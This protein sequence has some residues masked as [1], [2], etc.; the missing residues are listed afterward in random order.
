[1]SALFERLSAWLRRAIGR[2]TFEAD[3]AAELEFHIEAHADT[4]ERRGLPRAEALRQARLKFGATEKYR[5]EGREVSRYRHLDDLHADLR[6]AFRGLKRDPSFAV[7]AIAVVASVLA[8]N[9]VLLAFL[10]PYF[11]RPLPIDG[12]S[13]HVELSVRDG[14]GRSQEAWPLAAANRLI[15]ED[16]PV[17]ER[18]YLFSIR[19]VIVGGREPKRSYVEV[20]S[21]S[22]FKLVKPRL[23]IG[24]ALSADTRTIDRAILLSHTGWKRLTDADPRVL[25][26]QLLVDGDSLSVAGVLA[27]GTGGL[28]PVT[29]DFW[30]LAGASQIGPRAAS[31]TYSVGGL[32]REGV[33]ADQAA[34]ALTPIVRSLE[35]AEGGGPDHREARMQP[36]LT[37]LRESRE[38]RPL[39]VSL[40]FLFGLVTAVAAAN[41]TSMHLARA[42]ARR[43]DLSIRAA[44]GASR[45]RLIRHLLT[46]GVLISLIAALLACG[47]AMASVAAIQGIVF[48]VVSDFGMSMLPVRIDARVA[49]F[50]FALAF[51]IGIGC[52][53]LPALQTTRMHRTIA[54]KRDGLWLSGTLSSGRLRGAL[55]VLQVA[56]SLPL[57][58][59]AGI[60]V[61]SADNANRV[62]TGY[63]LD[64][65][66]DL[67]PEPPSTRLVERLRGLPGVRGV[68]MVG[69][70]PLGGYLP[71]VSVRFD[72]NEATLE[73]NEV[74]ENYFATIGIAL[75]QGRGFFPHE[76]ASRA[77]VA[78]ISQATARRL[79]PGR[80]PLGRAFEIE[81]TETK[82][83]YRRYEVIG[84]ADDVMSGMFFRGRDASAIYRP[85]TLEA[86]GVSSVVLRLDQEDA[87]ALEGLR[88]AC[89]ELGAFCEP[90]PIRKMLAQ[91]RV[92]FE[93]ASMIS[94]G[95]GLLALGLACLGLHGLVRFA[96]VQRTR[97]FGVRLA[98]GATRGQILTGVLGESVRRVGSGIAFGLPVCLGLSALIASRIRFHVLETFD[99]LSYSVMP[100]LLL[101]AALLASLFP[102]LRAA[103]TNPITALREE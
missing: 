84:V 79:W 58:V 1:M 77:P 38:L 45:G 81:D 46:E 78:V 2:D 14:E 75:R 101:V 4:L 16:N 30:M 55:V 35:P 99:P 82:G 18:G 70:A 80:S 66:I 11:L 63:R 28:E 22:Y 43:H 25:G 88:T 64:G 96:V 7:V 67:R 23:A 48:S 59:G 87:P 21:P 95:L 73:T 10:D 92:P 20:V 72:G 31:A 50:A 54:L 85:A 39:A 74:D 103:G 51:V 83:Q 98:I 37:L 19:R 47:L 56:L 15:A 36:R 57:L 60:F 62:D 102:A 9:M 33:S 93:I 49:A 3:M 65:L 13:R 41:L 12:A 42:T 69:N 24:R 91:Q 53:L 100:L 71:R 86:A 26:R 97:E 29:P 17:L 27:E 44:L 89:A 68:T 34:A 40:L 32:L 6:D 76:A 61:R 5:Q 90:L 52:G 8:A 94:S